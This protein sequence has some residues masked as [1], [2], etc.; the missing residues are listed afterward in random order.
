MCWKCLTMVKSDGITVLFITFLLWFQKVRLTSLRKLKS[1][2]LQNH[3][4]SGKTDTKSFPV[5]MRMLWS[6]FPLLVFFL[7]LVTLCLGV[8]GVRRQA[9][10]QAGEAALCQS[11][12]FLFLWGYSTCW[13]NRKWLLPTL[14]FFCCFL[15]ELSWLMEQSVSAE[16][17][18]R[19]I[20][21]LRWGTQ[22]SLLVSVN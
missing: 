13:P 11:W 18:T 20:V 10:T 21:R 15:A 8:Q 7:C 22:P 14:T 19:G 2:M 4:V 3:R 5:N 9:H 12:T 17:Q 16:H 6:S 1:T